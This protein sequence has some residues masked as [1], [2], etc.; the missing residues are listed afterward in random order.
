MANHRVIFLKSLADTMQEHLTYLLFLILPLYFLSSC[1]LNSNEIPYDT[2][3]PE[4]EEFDAFFGAWGKLGNKIV[5][6]HDEPLDGTADAGKLDQVWIYDLQTQERR[7]V[8]GGR[9]YA[10]KLHPDGDWI[11]FHTNSFPQY[12][13]KVRLDGTGLTP[14]SGNS[15]PNDLEYTT[16]AR[17]SPNGQEILFTI[18]AG[19]PRGIA[20]MDTTG[21]DPEIIVPVGITGDWFPDGQQV[22]YVNWD[23]TS[24]ISMQRQIYTANRDGSNQTK[25][26]NLEESNIIAGP[27]VAP[28][29]TQIAFSHLGEGGRSEIF[30]MD[31]DGSNIRQL[32]QG[33]GDAYA[34]EWHPDGQKILFS[35]RIDFSSTERSRRLWLVDVETLQVTP[36]FPKD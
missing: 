11:I 5:F 6:I 30:I 24:A 17:F 9:A 36:L 2:D 4:S 21:T 13:Y 23:T 14:L 26:T 3:I 16:D 25:L 10:P 35:R 1:D 28:D 20:L 34:P 7:K 15:S 27:A 33:E 29:G 19:T 12:L 18:F 8:I 31:R 22:I 32:T